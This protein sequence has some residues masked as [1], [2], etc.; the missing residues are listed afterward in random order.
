MKKLSGK[1]A[2][3]TGGSSGIGLATARLFHAQGA[4]LIITGRDADSL[5]QAQQS[6]GEDVLAVQSDAGKL[7]DIERLA[8]TVKEHF[9]SLDILFVNAASAKPTPFESVTED[10]FD[11]IVA[12]NFK[13]VFFLIQKTLP[14]LTKGASVILTTSITNQ[15]ATPRFSIYAAC[16]AA[17]RSL[18][19][20]LGVELI[21]RGIRVNAISPGPTD[22]PGLGRCG[23]PQEIVEAIRT[24][25]QNRSPLKRFAEPD[26]I[27]NA[28][29]FLARAESSYFVG[30][31]LVVDGG[32]SLL[33]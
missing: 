17:Q 18:V 8:N 13:G 31:E 28:A 33:F 12:V 3:I 24:D 32:F 15:S 22:T 20:S 21:A 23:V 1:T 29:L 27:A 9:G 25:L 2:L 10:Q 7:D 19:Q 5:A 4:R 6:L 11:E 16:K 26:E 14:L 30:A